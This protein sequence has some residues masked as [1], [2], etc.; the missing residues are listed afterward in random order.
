MYISLDGKILYLTNKLNLTFQRLKKKQKQSSFL[1][2]TKSSKDSLLFF[3][4]FL[5]WLPCICCCHNPGC[6]HLVV[7]PSRGVFTAAEER[8]RAHAS[9]YNYLAHSSLTKTSHVTHWPARGL[10]MWSYHSKKENLIMLNAFNVKVLLSNK[11]QIKKKRL[12]RISNFY[13]RNSVY[14]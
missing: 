8:I 4:N 13:A 11:V 5:S 3:L 14:I 12:N 1:S 2:H 7:P 10:G 6:F 9:L